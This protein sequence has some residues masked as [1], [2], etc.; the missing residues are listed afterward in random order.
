MGVSFTRDGAGHVTIDVVALG[1][2]L[3]ALTSGGCQVLGSIRGSE[4]NIIAPQQ[5][6]IDYHESSNGRTHVRFSAIMSY[7]NTGRHGHDG[8]ITREFLQYTIGKRA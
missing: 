6:L 8:A 3:I 7:T 2:L 4:I 1:A 5:V